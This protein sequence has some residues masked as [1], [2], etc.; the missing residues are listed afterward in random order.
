[1]NILIT[2]ARRGLGLSLVSYFLKKGYN[3]YNIIRSDSYSLDNLKKEYSD[4]LFLYYGDVT[5][6][7]ALTDIVFSLK[8]DTDSLD[9]LINNAA[10]HFEQNAPDIDELDFSIYAPTFE[11]N[12][13]AP[14]KVIKNFLPFLRRG[15]KKWIANIS[16]EA[17]SIANCWRE[18]E[19]SYCMSKAALNMATAIL[20]NRLSKEGFTVCA[21]H[22]GWF[23]SDMGGSEAPISPYDAAEKVGNIILS[24]DTR[25]AYVDLEG[26][27]M[28]W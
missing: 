4:S 2:G 10:V 23:S 27:E 9:I 1:M 6:E 24:L 18:A 12:S 25:P 20:R 14:L 28:S 26:N 21:I 5:K 19:F 11:V 15:K 22:P 16:S 17:G 8:K 3:V 13:I 7:E